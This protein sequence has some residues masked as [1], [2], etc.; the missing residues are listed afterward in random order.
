MLF[1][2]VD[3]SLSVQ[4][5]NKKKDNLFL[6]KGVT[7]GLDDTTMTAEVEYSINFSRP[8]ENFV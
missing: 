5:D 8:Q 4:I 2:G 3:N 1:F 6:E 7:P